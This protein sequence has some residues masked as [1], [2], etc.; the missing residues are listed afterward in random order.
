MG[1]GRTVALSV[2]LAVLVGLAGACSS[3][4][5]KTSSAAHARA[6][7]AARAKKAAHRRQVAHRRAVRRRRARATAAARRLNQVQDARFVRTRRP[8]AANPAAD[9]ARIERSVNRLN[10][11]FDRSVA[12]GIAR[13]A[14]L[15][16]WVSRRVYDR[17]DCI[18]FESSL[19]ERAV[20]ERLVVHP[21][22]LRATPG[23]VDTAVGRTPGGRIYAVAVDEIQTFVPTSEQ[24]VT[25]RDLHA[26]V[27]RDGRARLFFRCA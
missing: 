7:A 8:R 27:G 22:T 10:A 4:D 24:R 26:T 5:S 21:E 23:W 20:A 19:G 11:A 25:L 16:Y 13:S 6:V 3:V 1:W 17:A 9:L 2:A 15:N 12:R 14:S 18:A